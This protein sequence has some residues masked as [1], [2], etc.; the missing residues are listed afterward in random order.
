MQA[1]C[2]ACALPVWAELG[3]EEA[4]A[5]AHCPRH[6]PLAPSSALRKA[7]LCKRDSVSAAEAPAEPG[8]CTVGWALGGQR[9]CGGRQ[10]GLVFR[11]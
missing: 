4:V 1:A 2:P 10:M 9:A 6:T 3:C 11:P 7:A 5:A 8:S